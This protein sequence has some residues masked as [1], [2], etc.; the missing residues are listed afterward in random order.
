MLSR[1]DE[2]Q[3]VGEE[4]PNFALSDALFQRPGREVVVDEMEAAGVRGRKG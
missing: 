4:G 3:K 1:E 2:A